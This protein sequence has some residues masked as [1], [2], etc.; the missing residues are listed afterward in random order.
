MPA[1]NFQGQFSDWPDSV[2]LL[3]VLILLLAILCP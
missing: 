2:I 3:F 1:R